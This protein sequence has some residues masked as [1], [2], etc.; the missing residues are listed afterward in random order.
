L[1]RRCP[2]ACTGRPRPTR[3]RRRECCRSTRACSTSRRGRLGGQSEK[4]RGSAQHYSALGARGGSSRSN[5][6]SKATSVGGGGLGLT[7]WGIAVTGDG[8]LLLLEDPA[9]APSDAA[10]TAAQSPGSAPGRPLGGCLQGRRLR[11]RRVSAAWRV[12][13]RW[14]RWR[15]VA[16][17][18][19]LGVAQLAAESGC[20]RELRARLG[21][22]GREPRGWEQPRRA[23]QPS[24]GPGR[25]SYERGCAGP[26]G[27]VGGSMDASVCRGVGRQGQCYRQRWLTTCNSR[28]SRKQPGQRPQ[29]RKLGGRGG[30]R[31]RSRAWRC[32]GG[33][34]AKAARRCRAES[35]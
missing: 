22:A 8:S 34:V 30:G 19:E 9:A 25:G 3:T 21:L 7:V 2:G 26:C 17:A 18:A 27:R 4:S 31:C 5:A 33:A 28:Q 12:C 10:A 6:G 13:A 29:S 24:G 15:A 23:R 32:R 1:S 14:W 16:G 35:R 11:S 20:A